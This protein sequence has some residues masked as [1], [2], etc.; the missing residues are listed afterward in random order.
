MKATATIGVSLSKKLPSACVSSSRESGFPRNAEKI[1][2]RRYE[3]RTH[4]G[5]ES[6]GQCS[7][8]TTQYFLNKCYALEPS[9]FWRF[10]CLKRREPLGRRVSGQGARIIH[11]TLATVE[12]HC[13]ACETPNQMMQKLTTCKRSGVTRCLYSSTI[14]R[15]V[16]PK[17]LASGLSPFPLYLLITSYCRTYNICLLTMLYF[18]GLTNSPHGAV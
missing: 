12:I 3:A 8:D 17:G 11:H 5:P 14:C 2:S 7:S 18:P 15:Q 9:R 13:Y 10:W 1:M 16:K 4:D 6:L